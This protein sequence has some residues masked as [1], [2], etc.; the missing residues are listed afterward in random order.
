MRVSKILLSICIFLGPAGCTHQQ[1]VAFDRAVGIVNTSAAI[2]QR[3]EMIRQQEIANAQQQ[4]LIAQNAVALHISQEKTLKE[5]VKEEIEKAKKEAREEVSLEK[6][7]IDADKANKSR[8]PKG[9][10]DENQV[11]AAQENKV[12]CKIGDNP[13]IVIDRSVCTKANGEELN[14]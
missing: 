2:A 6:K 9:K 7:S 4:A 13:A 14:D 10:K 12:R 11:I 5:Q 3:Q 8:K 1:L